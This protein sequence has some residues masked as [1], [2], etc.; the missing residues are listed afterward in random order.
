[1]SLRERQKRETRLHIQEVAKSFIAENGYEKTTIRALAKAAGVGVG[2]ISLH[3]KDKKSLLL[4]SFHQEI[5]EVAVT[6]IGTVPQG[7][8]LREQLLHILNEVYRYYATNTQYLRAVVKEALFVS[9]EWGE[10]F[11]RQIQECIG[12][13]VV[14]L[15][16]AK[17]RGEVRSDFDS[18]AATMVFWSIYINGLIDGL[19]QDDFLPDVQTAKV[20]PLVDVV[21]AGATS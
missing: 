7:K 8:P 18:P 16:E 19:K 5:G 10:I 3:F 9:G 14:L 2:T 11:D 17:K 13:V 1:M 4:A 6:A 15:E 12:L 21:L 20:M